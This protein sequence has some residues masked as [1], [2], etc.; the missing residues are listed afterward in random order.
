MAGQG[1]PSS[2]PCMA[3]A[4]TSANARAVAPRPPR[5]P[6]ALGRPRN[7]Y[8]FPQSAA[9]S[10]G[11]RVP[12]FSVISSLG[13]QHRDILASVAGQPGRSHACVLLGRAALASRPLPVPRQQSPARPPPF[14]WLAPARSPQVPPF[15][16]P[17]EAH[18]LPWEQK[19]DVAFWRCGAASAGAAMHARLLGCTPPVGAAAKCPSSSSPAARR[20]TP[21]CNAHPLANDS[22]T[23]KLTGCSREV[24]TLL[25]QEHPGALNV[26]LLR[27]HGRAPGRPGP[28]TTHAEHARYK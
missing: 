14:V 19:A 17:Y 26:S 16:P 23:S 7:V 1:P 5:R 15:L 20:G 21:W 3:H 28:K 27:P 10:P 9:G 18:R 4:S 13:G 24:L 8:D 22:H 12:L 6:P 2:Q 11:A 25:S